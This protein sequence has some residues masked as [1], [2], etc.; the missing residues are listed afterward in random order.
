MRYTQLQFSSLFQYR[1]A[2]SFTC[3]LA[4]CFELCTTGSTEYRTGLVRFLW[5][6]D[7]F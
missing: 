2:K 6:K 4:Y 3:Q 1:A 5:S 7:S